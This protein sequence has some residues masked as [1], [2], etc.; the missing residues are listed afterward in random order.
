MNWNAE[1]LQR[2]RAY[3]GA[4][5]ILAEIVENE[6]W[7]DRPESRFRWRVTV[8]GGLVGWCESLDVAKQLATGF[9]HNRGLRVMTRMSNSTSDT[10]AL[11][12]R[13]AKE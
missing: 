7:P 12:P 13:H 10:P 6:N 8:D 5:T 11:P 3:S 2:Y 1:P 9:L 4:G